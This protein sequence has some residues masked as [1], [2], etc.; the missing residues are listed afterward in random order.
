MIEI[1]VDDKQIQKYLIKLARISSDLTPIMQEIAGIMH[2]AVE[3]NFEQ[4]GRPKWRPSQRAIREGGQTLK[5]TGRL[6]SSIR[7]QYDSRSAAVGVGGDI[8]YAKIHQFGGRTPPT[9]ILPRRKQALFWP[10][11]RHPVKKVR[12]PGSRIPARPFLTLTDEDKKEI[13][14][15]LRR[16]LRP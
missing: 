8:P 9:T 4:G 15:T 11:A 1:K 13:V 2:D 5:D 10:G 16:F 7:E 14:E 3:E 12:H 6:V